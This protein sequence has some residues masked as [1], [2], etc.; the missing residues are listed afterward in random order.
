[1]LKNDMPHVPVILQVTIGVVGQN[2]EN[3]VNHAVEANGQDSDKGL[4]DLV[5]LIESVNP[6]IAILYRANQDQVDHFVNITCIM[7]III[8]L[9]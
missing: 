9:L 8:T 5:P 6:K 2:M 7:M 3:V 1:M 4:V